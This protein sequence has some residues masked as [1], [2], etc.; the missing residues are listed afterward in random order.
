MNRGSA[1]A[2]EILAAALK[3]SYGATLVGETT[4]GKGTVQTTRTL[5]SGAQIKYTIQK[6]LT[7][8]GNWINGEGIKPDIEVSLTNEDIV[9]GKDTQLDKA[10]EVL[11]EK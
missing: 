5:S 1:S 2:S 8:N 9:N 7:P 11:I 3:E 6:W 4:F 10:I